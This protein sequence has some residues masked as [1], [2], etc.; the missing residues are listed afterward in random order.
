MF[1]TDIAAPANTAFNKVYLLPVRM[2]ILNLAARLKMA[3]SDSFPTGASESKFYGGTSG[4]EGSFGGMF[5]GVPG[6]YEYTGNVAEGGELTTDADGELEVSADWTFSPNSNLATVK[7]PDTAYTYFGWWLNKP[8]L[9]SG[10]HDVEVFAGGTATAAPLNEAMVGNAT[11]TGPAAGKYV[12]KTFTAG[13]QTDAGVGH[14]TATANVTARFGLATGDVGT[15]GGSVT[16]FVLDDARAASWTV[17][18]EDVTLNTDAT[19]NGT[20]EV[21]FGGGLTATENGGAGTWEGSFYDTDTDDAKG[22]Q[23]VVGRFDAVTEAAS[24]IGAFGAKRQ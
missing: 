13:A 4:N 11:Y 8:K 9:N 16:G 5:D 3:R 15:I 18:L 17:K 2:D 21:N 12:T 1:H 20:S 23:T 7:V 14:F 6:T 22:P 24:V 19:F 10:V